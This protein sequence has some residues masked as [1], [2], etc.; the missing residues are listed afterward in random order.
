MKYPL[1][2]LIVAFVSVAAYA[3]DTSSSDSQSKEINAR[4]Q[5]TTPAD[6][7]KQT[8]VTP[9]TTQRTDDPLVSSWSLLDQGW[10]QFGNQQQTGK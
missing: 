8:A 4:T 10:K 1:I 5:M 2:V 6:Q 7:A 3:G 9:A